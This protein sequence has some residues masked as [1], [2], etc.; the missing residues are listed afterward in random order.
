MTP[1]MGD[2]IR[3]LSSNMTASSRSVRRWA[4]L[5]VEQSWRRRSTA[6][7]R[8]APSLNGAASRRPRES[9]RMPRGVR[10]DKR[11]PIVPGERSKCPMRRG[12]RAEREPVAGRDNG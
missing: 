8:A 1:W 4:A 6:A 12:H 5:V 9:V 11:D 2:W 3:L 10:A 7:S